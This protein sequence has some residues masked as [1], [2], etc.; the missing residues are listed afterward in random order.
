M[1][2]MIISDPYE[3]V[4]V[5]EMEDDP[6]EERQLAAWQYLVDTGIAWQLQGF[7]GRTARDL[8]NRG[9]ITEKT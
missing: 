9:L 7:Y 2:D 1:T 8:I 4:S 6:S 3:A 5:I